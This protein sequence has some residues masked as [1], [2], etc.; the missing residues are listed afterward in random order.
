MIPV[1]STIYEQNVKMRE[2][3]ETEIGEYKKDG[4]TIILGDMNSRIENLMTII[5]KDTLYER[6]NIDKKENHN[7]RELIKLMNITGMMILTGIKKKSDFTCYKERRR[8]TK[9]K[10]FEWKR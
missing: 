4:V 1:G 8:K 6:N 7:G 9:N 2:E 3:L 5:N 10:G